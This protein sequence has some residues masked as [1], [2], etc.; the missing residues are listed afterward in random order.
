MKR[1]ILLSTIVLMLCVIVAKSNSISSREK[2]LNQMEQFFIETLKQ[3]YGNHA[4]TDLYK[5]FFENYIHND[6]YLLNVDRKKIKDINDELFSNDTIYYYFYNKVTFVSVRDSVSLVTNALK[7]NP[8]CEQRVVY[9]ENYHRKKCIGTFYNTF[10]NHDG[11]LKDEV[12][13]KSDNYA[14]FNI[15][16]GIDKTLDSQGMIYMAPRLLEHENELSIPVV[17]KYITVVYWNYLCRCAN[18][19]LHHRMKIGKYNCNE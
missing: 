9:C 3:N 8:N 1:K 15:I 5:M 16:R 14:I 18:Y 11:F 4:E 6:N 17:K 2:I 12:L 19:D 13:N 7:V 10:C